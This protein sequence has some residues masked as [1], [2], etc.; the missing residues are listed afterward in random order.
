MAEAALL[1][2]RQT[3]RTKIL[4]AETVHPHYREVLRTYCAGTP[5]TIEE[6]GYDPGGGFNPN[7]FSTKLTEDVAGAIFQ[8]PNFL[9]VVEDLEGISEK[10][11]AL[12][13][14]MILVVNPLSLGVL[15]SPA[16]WGADVAV[17]EGQPLGIPPQYGGPYLGLF[18]ATKAL[19]RRIPGR[20]A[21]ITQDAKGR[22]AYCLTLQAR[23]QHIRRERAASNIC[24]NQSLCALAACVYM[25]L[26]GKT[27]IRQIGEL[28]LDRA[29]YLREKIT[30]LSGFH[31]AL[32]VPV[33]N[34]FVIQSEKSM[35]EVEKKLK[36]ENILPGIRLD[37]FY[38]NMKNAMLVCAT[39]TK[40]KD[41]LDRFVEVLSQ[42]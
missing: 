32:D 5:Y 17:G 3:D 25:T 7:E 13:A 22:R 40:T 18:A 20:L 39:E 2:L 36:Q 16:E 12:G 19:T 1:V 27:G 29:H 37:R 10:L 14:L 33:F 4:V 9:G 15:R 34:E 6:F 24:T 21:G 41:E 35:D 11:H 23:E 42:C 26:L 8:T 28:N 38:P 31:T 30:E